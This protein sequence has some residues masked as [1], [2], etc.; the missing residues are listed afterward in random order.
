MRLRKSRSVHLV[1]EQ[2]VG[3]HRIGQRHAAREVLRHFHVPNRLYAGIG[4]PEDDFD[5]SIHY[6]GLLEQRSERGAAPLGGADPA[7]EPWEAMVAAAL[8]R[9]DDLLLGSGLERR[10]RQCHRLLHQAGDLQVPLL[11]VDDGLV[12]VRH[13]KE[14]VG[15]R[16]KRGE[17]VFPRLQVLDYTAARVGSRLIQPRHDFLAWPTRKCLREPRRMKQ[18]ESSAT[19]D[20]QLAAGN[21]WIVH[22]A[23]LF[24]AGSAMRLFIIDLSAA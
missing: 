20:Q 6:A 24:Y 11:F 9:E 12:V 3:A 8:E 16:Q 22:H 2:V 13:A 18:R 1:T 10:Q 4:S 7:G 14:L 21:V 17:E 15:G 5:A 23:L 19:L